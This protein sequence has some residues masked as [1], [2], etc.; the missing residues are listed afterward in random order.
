MQ[1]QE[2]IREPLHPE[3]DID[4]DW[5]S[6]SLGGGENFVE[7]TPTR[8]LRT[9]PVERISPVLQPRVAEFDTHAR[10]TSNSAYVDCMSA[11]C[12]G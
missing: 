2:N 12:G 5:F 10:G 4:N 11:C 1:V 3:E 6:L 8:S 7:S 9:S